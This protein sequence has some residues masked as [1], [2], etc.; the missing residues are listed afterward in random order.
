MHRIGFLINPIAG[1]G[2]R[3]GLK[4]TDGMLKEAIERGAK[5]V[6]PVRAREFLQHFTTNHT[7]HID[8]LFILTAGDPMGASICS[9]FEVAYKTSYVPVSAH[10]TKNDTMNAVRMF[11]EENCELI[12]FCGGDGTARDIV[13]VVKDRV[14]ILGI[15]AGVKMYSSVFATTPESAAHVL[16][17]FINGNVRIGN[18]DILDVD[19]EA[20]RQG[21][22][23][24]KLYGICKT[25]VEPEFVQSGKTMIEVDESEIL[26]GI[27][28]HVIEKMDE[29][30]D[31]LFILGPG[32]TVAH[33][34]S[35]LGIEKTLLGI[36]C[37]HAKK[38]I[39]R[40]VAEQELL[41]LLGRYQRA[42]LVLSPIGGQGFVIGRGNQQIS[43]EVLK[44][45][46]LENIMVIA[47]PA[48]LST[49]PALRFDIP[50]REIMD[51][52]KVVKYFPVIT[53]YHTSMIK[54]VQV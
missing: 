38:L 4:G 45:I 43:P 32:T 46:G 54:M 7:E 5:P 51:K 33:V 28:E 13:E 12:V 48:K 18:G 8:A 34:A 17:D 41:G 26:D 20:Y 37:V 19:E 22:W 44:R 24:V 11:L 39:A 21:I 14:P 53:G 25:L 15:P 23:N 52:L 3:V 42:V 6:A 31:A 40:D 2:G 16:S 47:T 35:K 29:M 27:A 10:T 1:M 49:I 36:D 9:Q 50:E 30:A